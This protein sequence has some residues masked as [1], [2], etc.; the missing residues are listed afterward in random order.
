MT[1][2]TGEGTSFKLLVPAS[3]SPEAEEVTPTCLDTNAPLLG[4]VLLLDD[5]PGVRQSLSHMLK[6]LGLEVEATEEGSQALTLYEKM[7]NAGS[8]PDI[9]LM[10]LTIPGGLGGLEIIAPLLEMD[11]K[12]KAIVISGYSHNPVISEFRNHGFKAAIAKPILV[13]E[14]GNI[15]RKVLAES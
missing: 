4:T 13:A 14:L 5:D 2:S 8:A 7:M 12:A 9:V 3:T 15:L 6:S 11:P 1:S 10:D